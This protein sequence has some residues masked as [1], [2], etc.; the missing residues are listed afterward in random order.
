MLFKRTIIA[1]LFRL[2]PL[3]GVFRY[4]KKRVM[5]VPDVLVVAHILI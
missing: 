5:F 3:S 2:N 1:S 4:I